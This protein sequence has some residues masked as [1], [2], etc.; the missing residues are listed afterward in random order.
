[1]SL[2]EMGRRQGVPDKVMEGLEA[3]GAF[4]ASALRRGIGNGV[5][6]AMGR[7]VAAAVLRAIAE[8]QHDRSAA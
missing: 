3:H 5:P 1:M 6:L 2:A 4:T 7:A 8:P